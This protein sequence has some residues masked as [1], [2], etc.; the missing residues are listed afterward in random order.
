MRSI[1]ITSKLEEGNHQ[2]QYT[3]YNS[4]HEVPSAKTL[5]LKRIAAGVYQTDEWQVT[6]ME[7]GWWILSHR[8]NLNSY[9]D[10]ITNFAIAKIDLAYEL[11]IDTEIA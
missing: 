4:T 10:P 2:M 5:G 6:Q 3:I 8:T 11:G 1:L 7:Q 9:S